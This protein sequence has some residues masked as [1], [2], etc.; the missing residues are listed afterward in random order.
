MLSYSSR[1]LACSEGGPFVVSFHGVSIQRFMIETAHGRLDI[2]SFSHIKVL[3]EVLISAPP[4]GVDHR[5]ALVPSNLMEVGVSN[6]VLLAI[7]WESPVCMWSVIEFVDLTD[8][9]FPLGNHAFLL[10]LGEEVEHKGLVEMPNQEHIDNSDSVLAGKLCNLPEGVA[11]WIL[12]ESGDVLE[13]SPF[14]SHVSGL[15][16]LSYELGEI[17]IGLLGKCSADHVCSLIHVG[18]SVHQ[19]FNASQSLSEVRLWILSVV[20]VLSHY[21]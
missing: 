2:M 18:V 8:V 15:G 13:C 16:G 6:V 20:Q 10:L 14:L 19:A 3:S 21:I 12:K 9:P 1:S 17:T 5:D 4:V 7:D 11:K